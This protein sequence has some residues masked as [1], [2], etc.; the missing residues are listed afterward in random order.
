M[1]PGTLFKVRLD[2]GIPRPVVEPLA[3]FDLTDKNIV[4]SKSLQSKDLKRKYPE[5]MLF[6]L[7]SS[8]SEYHVD[9]VL[10]LFP[11]LG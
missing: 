3:T 9:H 11:M 4:I 8:G 10:E 7:Y 2:D 1:Q 5:E 6:Y